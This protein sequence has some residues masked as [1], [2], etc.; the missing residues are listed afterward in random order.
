MT[1]EDSF[2][3]IRLIDLSIILERHWSGKSVSMLIIVSND[4]GHWN[5]TASVRA[6]LPWLSGLSIWRGKVL[7]VP[8]KDSFCFS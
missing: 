8:L 4:Y 2:E 7:S 5:S 6:V 3:T 1:E